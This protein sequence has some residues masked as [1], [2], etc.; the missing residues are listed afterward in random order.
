MTDVPQS[1]VILDISGSSGKAGVIKRGLEY[2]SKASSEAKLV[3]F[4]KV[5]QDPP[6]AGD[7]LNG[8]TESEC[9]HNSSTGKDTRGTYGLLQFNLSCTN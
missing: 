5:F 6:N 1:G 4:A 9:S 2:D 8:R 3:Y 7:I